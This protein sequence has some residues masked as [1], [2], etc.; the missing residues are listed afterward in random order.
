MI[1]LGLIWVRNCEMLLLCIFKTYHLGDQ[2]CHSN[3]QHYL[4]LS[5]LHCIIQQ[6]RQIHEKVNFLLI[7]MIKSNSV[8]IIHFDTKYVVCILFHTYI[9]SLFIKD[10][11]TVQFHWLINNYVSVVNLIIRTRT[12]RHWFVTIIYSYKNKFSVLTLWTI[13]CNSIGQQIVMQES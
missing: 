8:P 12:L 1:M 2:H 3:N 6:R 7:L 5:A 4:N 11:G 10:I 9:R 13:K